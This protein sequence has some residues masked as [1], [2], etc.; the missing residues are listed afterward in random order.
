MDHVANSH[1]P[2]SSRP[3]CVKT[4]TLGYDEPLAVDQLLKMI[5]PLALATKMKVIP[6]PLAAPNAADKT[7]AVNN[8]LSPFTQKQLTALPI[9]NRWR[10]G[11][12]PP[13]E[14]INVTDGLIQVGVK[15]FT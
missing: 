1:R 12:N 14:A 15:S 7:V 9:P 5:A 10:R 11:V 3:A 2:L 8:L 4:S 6:S 13:E